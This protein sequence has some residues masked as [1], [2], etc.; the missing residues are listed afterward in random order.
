M[1]DEYAFLTGTAQTSLLHFDEYA[2]QLT[3]RLSLGSRDL[4][5]DIGSN[6]GTLLQAFKSHGARVLGIEPAQNVAKHAIAAGIE[7]LV[8]YFGPGTVNAI[9]LGNAKVVTANNVVSHVADLSG[10]LDSVARV[11]NPSG[12]FAFEVPWV[13]DVLR[14]HSFDIVYHEHLSYFGFKPLSRLLQKHKLDLIDLQY[15]PNIHGGTLRGLAAHSKSYPTREASLNRIFSDEESQ[16]D[17]LSLQKFATFVLEYRTKL[18]S[19]LRNLK[20]DGKRI[21]GYGAPAK[22]TILLNFCSI[23]RSILDY[24]TDTTPLKQGKF[25]PGVRV[26]VVPP[27]RMH[28]SP[29]DYALLLAW[30]FKDEI[31]QKEQGFLRSGGKFILPFPEPTI[32]G[33]DQSAEKNY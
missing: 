31:I 15:F 10:F 5:V 33:P 23:D 32:V 2:D 30:N 28:E 12:I 13:V 3:N 9:G 1:Y 29:P 18:V 7:T 27:V 26:P 24:V 22:A 8:E 4:V 11:L 19:M 6:D 21:V 20:R 14:H 17:L 16:A 25:I